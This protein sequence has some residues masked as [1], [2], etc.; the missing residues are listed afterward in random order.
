[1]IEHQSETAFLSHIL[2]YGERDECR[3]LQ[4]SVAQVQQDVRRVKRVASVTVLFSLVAIAGLLYGA[5]LH[6]NFPFNGAERVFTIL[7]ALGLASLTYLAC[8][9]VLLTVYRT[10][11]NRLRKECRQLAVRLLESRW[12]APPS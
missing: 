7:C 6:A 1:M 3:K 2:L 9:A 4:K 11:L 10:K 8:Y 5:I 12:G